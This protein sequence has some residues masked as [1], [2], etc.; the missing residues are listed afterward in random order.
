MSA[1]YRL[2][3]TH[4]IDPHEFATAYVDHVE[5]TGNRPDPAE[6]FAR[7]RTTGTI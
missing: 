5:A 3:Y 7:W 1:L 4:D 6:A 2:L